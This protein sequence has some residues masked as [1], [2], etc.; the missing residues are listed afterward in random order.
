MLRYYK[1][2]PFPGK[3]HCDK[4]MNLTRANNK[5]VTPFPEKVSETGAAIHKYVHDLS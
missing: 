1:R 5:V 2:N 3:G 4:K